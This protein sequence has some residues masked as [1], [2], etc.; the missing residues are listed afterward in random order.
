M[1]HAK[2]LLMIHDMQTTSARAFA[3]SGRMVETCR[4]GAATRA[5][6]A[7]QAADQAALRAAI[8]TDARPAEDRARDPDRRP[9]EVLSFL[10]LRPGMQV[11]DL[12]AGG[13]FYTEILARLVGPRGRVFAQNSPFVLASFAEQPLRERLARLRMDHVQ[14]L[15]TEFDEPGLPAGALDAALM[16]LYYHDVYW[17][18]TDR[19]RMKQAVFD[20]LRPGG[21]F[22]VIDHH[23]PAGSRDRHVEDL[24]R[25]DAAMVKQE[26][27][28]AGFVL[29]GE[30]DLLR[31]PGDDRTRNVFDP[32]VR[33]KTDRFLYR[34]RKPA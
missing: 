23:A 3:S 17:L 28:D 29:D 5:R 7:G 31:Q 12:A 32:A 33:G 27:L 10:G 4:S 2:H 21:V 19:A 18:G 20:A 11:A 16:F 6:R 34:F 30:S 14:R 13:G 26:I 9:F 25:V 1:K 8:E 15:D 24:H 22:A